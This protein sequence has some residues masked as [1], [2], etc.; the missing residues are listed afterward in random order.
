MSN[1]VVRST[2]KRDR[3]TAAT[4]RCGGSS[5]DRCVGVHRVAFAVRTSVVRRVAFAVRTPDAYVVRATS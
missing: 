2:V 3:H 1:K 5:W 4:R